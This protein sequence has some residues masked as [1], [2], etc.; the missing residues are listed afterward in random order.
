MGSTGGYNTAKN[1]PSLL[2]PSWLTLFA[3]VSLPPQGKVIL[4]SCRNGVGKAEF[5]EEKREVNPDI[6][7]QKKK[8]K[9]TSQHEAGV[10]LPW[11]KNILMTKKYRNAILLP[12]YFAVPRVQHQLGSNP[13]SQEFFLSLSYLPLSPHRSAPRGLSSVLLLSA[14]KELLRRARD[15]RCA[16]QSWRL[17]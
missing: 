1:A 12:N 10:M 17:L 11:G 4:T 9:E 2:H 16:D 6:S 3:L 15:A 13:C 14:Q 8:R 7:T 5:Q